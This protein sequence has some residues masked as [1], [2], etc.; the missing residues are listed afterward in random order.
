ME[1]KYMFI[2]SFDYCT[3]HINAHKAE[4]KAMEQ[5]ASREDNAASSHGNPVEQ[6]D[7]TSFDDRWSAAEVGF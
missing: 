1:M 4:Y 5:S 6:S 2:S 3:K 7:D